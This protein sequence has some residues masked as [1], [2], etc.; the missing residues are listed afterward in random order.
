MKQ[1]TD[2]PNSLD[3]L[4][5]GVHTS[6]EAYPNVKYK[7]KALMSLDHL[8][9]GEIN[10]PMPNKINF[11]AIGTLKK[12]IYGTFNI[13]KSHIKILFKYL[14]R[15]YCKH[16]YV[17]Y[18]ATFL[19][20]LF[21]F[22]PRFRPHGKIVIDAFISIYDTVVNDRKL[23]SPPSLLA[24]LLKRIETRA[25]NFADIVITDTEQNKIFYSA[26]FGLPE[27]KFIA[28]PLSTNEEAFYDTP[29]KP[30]SDIIKIL[31]VG[32]MIPLH[33][34]ETI[35]QAAD[36]LQ[37]NNKLSFTIIGNGQDSKLVENYINEHPD[38][39]EWINIWQSPE[40]IASYIKKADICLGIFGTG[41]KTQRVCPYKI[42]SYMS[43]GRA[44][45]TAETKWTSEVKINA[46]FS[47]FSTVPPGNSNALAD[48]II[49]ISENPKERSHLA[50]SGYQFY[51]KNLSNQVSTDKL[52]K[53]FPS[54]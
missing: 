20:F 9:I 51:S 36:L 19:L 52:E 43:C 40:Q 25:F 21:S 32:T 50:L 10:A 35:L 39:I 29:Y 22:F 26:L 42:Y 44:I 37:S 7:I 45:I 11:G 46:G 2:E 34:I 17:P 49:R 53:L 18:P 24:R 23:I 15:P 4:I 38:K 8:K 28:I 48:E 6:S 12:F 27:E 1:N 13:S 54:D 47:P 33:G 31:F 5:L 3:V 41:K 16:I 30:S 14:V